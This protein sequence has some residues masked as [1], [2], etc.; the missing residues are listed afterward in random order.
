MGL[1][2]TCTASFGGRSSEGRALLETDELLFRGEFRLKI[3]FRAISEVRASGATLHVVWSEG[4]AKLALGPAA[5]TWAERI[6]NPKS[7]LDKLDVKPGKKIAVTGLDDREFLKELRVPKFASGRVPKGAEIVFFGAP[8]GSALS[9]LAALRKT[10]APNGAIWV[11]Y[12]K[13]RDDIGE[14]RVRDAGR[15]AGLVDI[16]VARFSDT[17]GALKLVIPVAQRPK[18]AQK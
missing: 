1:E 4:T 7:R 3:P 16:K 9:R 12:P 14:D 17:H 13:E 10:I 6:R 18:A 11:I 8:R 15:C 2:A 5:A